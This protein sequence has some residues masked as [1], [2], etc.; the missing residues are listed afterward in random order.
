MDSLKML[1]TLWGG[2]IYRLELDLLLHRCKIYVKIEEVNNMKFYE[3]DFQEVLSFNIQDETTNPRYYAEL[4]EIYY[5][6]KEHYEF[7][8]ML[9][10]ETN[11]IN[12]VCKDFKCTFI[13]ETGF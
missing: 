5:S 1:D 12:I 8:I 9:W 13:T 6:K 10:S 4:T 11:T 2:N 3:L 7:T